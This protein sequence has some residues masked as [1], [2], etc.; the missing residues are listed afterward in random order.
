MTVITALPTRQQHFQITPID[1]TPATLGVTAPVVLRG[2]NVDYGC[3]VIPEVQTTNETTSVGSV[4]AY[5][6]MALT[7]R[8]T[9]GEIEF[10]IL[11]KTDTRWLQQLK[12]G[13]AVLHTEDN[14]GATGS[15]ETYNFLCTNVRKDTSDGVRKFVVTLVPQ[16]LV[17]A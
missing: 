9:L 13:T 15:S 10:T 7:G 8:T 4:G 5:N 1:P 16:D 12:A 3:E 17:I 11:N 6:K 14:T 2:N